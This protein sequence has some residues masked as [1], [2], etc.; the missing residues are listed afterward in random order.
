FL[1]ARTHGGDWTNAPAYASRK[2]RSNPS[3]LA[4][5]SDGSSPATFY[6]THAATIRGAATR[7]RGSPE[8]KRDGR[9]RGSCRA[10]CKGQARSTPRD[11]RRLVVVGRAARAA[12][13]S[14]PLSGR[15]AP[16]R[17]AHEHQ[18]GGGWV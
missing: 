3:P 9:R 6:A 5:G 10:R 7:R 4:A 14:R 1:L 13:I 8:G 15:H 18:S 17:R 12:R 2:S 16:S 11:R